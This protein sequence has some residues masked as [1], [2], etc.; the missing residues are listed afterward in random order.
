MI[1]DDL[2][3]INA[4]DE[5]LYLKFKNLSLSGSTEGNMM[6]LKAI[7]HLRGFTLIELITTIAVAAIASTIITPSALN[8]CKKA[9][10]KASV[11]NFSPC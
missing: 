9:E 6:T 10:L 11:M 8:S 2:L 4:K 7:V 5:I 3:L 1:W